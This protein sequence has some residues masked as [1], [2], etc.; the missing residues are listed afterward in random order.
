MD[1]IKVYQAMRPL[2]EACRESS[3]PVFLDVR[4]YRYKGH[5]MSDPRRY[6]TKEEEQRYE[7]KDPIERLRQRLSQEQGMSPEEYD[8]LARAVRKEVQEAVRW[9]EESPEPPREE[10]YTDVYAEPWGPYLG[11]SPPLL[12]REAERGRPRDEGPARRTGSEPQR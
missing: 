1:V 5:S 12:V 7:E 10:L 3:R 9:A 4:T 8:E 2:V 6:R 11:T